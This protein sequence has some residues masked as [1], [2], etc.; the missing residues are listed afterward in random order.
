MK[1]KASSSSQVSTSRYEQDLAVASSTGVVFSSTTS[2]SG[3]QVGGTEDHSTSAQSIISAG[4][5]NRSSTSMEVPL[6]CVQIQ[7]QNP[8][9]KIPSQEHKSTSD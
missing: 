1:N 3:A 5:F 4:V 7:N 9:K 2:R 8:A 6:P